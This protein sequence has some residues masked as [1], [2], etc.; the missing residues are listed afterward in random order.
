MRAWR[1][2]DQ[3][4]SPDRPGPWAAMIGRREALR[5]LAGRRDHIELASGGDAA[6][7]LP[8]PLT[9]LGLREAVRGLPVQDR[10]LLGLRYDADLS[11]AEVAQLLDT[12]AGTVAVRLHRAR[13]RLRNA[14]GV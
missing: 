12:P 6:A 1:C 4:A 5:L 8:D 14:L 7:V 10:L 11:Q 9:S 13:H 3:C 2:R